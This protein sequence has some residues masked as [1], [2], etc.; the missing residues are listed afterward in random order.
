[1]WD[2]ERSCVWQ[3][4][5]SVSPLFL[6]LPDCLNPQTAKETEALHCY[7]TCW[8]TL[9]GW[10]ARL[11]AVRYSNHFDLHWVICREKSEVGVVLQIFPMARYPSWDKLIPRNVNADILVI[12]SCNLGSGGWQERE[13]STL[14]LRCSLSWGANTYASHHQ[15]TPSI[16]GLSASILSSS[17]SFIQ[18]TF[19]ACTVQIEHWVCITG[20]ASNLRSFL[21]N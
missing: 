3:M 7:H 20:M 19:I 5:A 6:H 9:P 1:M 12:F 14:V 13:S 15:P 18:L 21:N 11:Q 10:L 4:S 16:N 8:W 2:S 17:F